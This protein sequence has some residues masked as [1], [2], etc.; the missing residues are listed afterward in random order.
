MSE[1]KRTGLW[2]RVNLLVTSDHGMAQCSAERL[3]R[4]DDCL[5]PDNYTLVDL[6]PV[7]AL[8][9]NTGS[10]AGLMQRELQ[11]F[12]VVC[13]YKFVSVADPEAVFSLLN[14]CHANMTAYLKKAIPDRLHY[15][16]SE[17][18][19]PILLIADEGWTI[20]QRGNKLPRCESSV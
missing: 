14:K 16:N 12:S 8:I 19:Q 10:Q 6:T 11:L 17:R 13:C 18:I 20:V 2:G 4:L 3:I 15:Q 1:L 7:A 5:H 9:P